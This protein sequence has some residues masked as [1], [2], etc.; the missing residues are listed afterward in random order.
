MWQI[1]KAYWRPLLE[2]PREKVMRLDRHLLP[3]HLTNKCQCCHRIN[4]L[5][6]TD[7][8]SFGREMETSDGG[9]VQSCARRL[10]SH[11]FQPNAKSTPI[12]AIGKNRR[13]LPIGVRIKRDGVDGVPSIISLR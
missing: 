10:A 6:S 5:S 1:G 13:R 12:S 11:R 9:S 3:P 7:G 2:R 8:S 4:G